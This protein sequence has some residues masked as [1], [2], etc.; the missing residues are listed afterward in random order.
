LNRAIVNFVPTIATAEGS[1]QTLRHIP[2]CSCHRPPH[3]FLPVFPSSWLG[4]YYKNIGSSSHE[5]A[6]PAVLSRQSRATGKVSARFLLRMNG[7]MWNRIHVVRPS[8]SSYNLGARAS[9]KNIWNT[10]TVT[11]SPMTDPSPGSWSYDHDKHNGAYDMFML[12]SVNDIILTRHWVTLYLYKLIDV[13]VHN[14][15]LFLII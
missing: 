13:F 3:F 5:N 2:C 14:I 8:A 6:S 7:G 11:S 1:S 4:H 9:W 12:R 15:F 10:C